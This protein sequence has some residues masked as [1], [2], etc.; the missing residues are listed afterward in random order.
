MG[1][2][3]TAVEPTLPAYGGPYVYEDEDGRPLFRIRRNPCGNPR[4]I[5]EH[6]GTRPAVDTP[7]GGW[8]AHEDWLPGLGG[9]RRVLYR[10]PQLIAASQRGVTEVHICSGEKDDEAAEDV[11]V[12]ATTN[13][14]GETSRWLD[15]YSECLRS[16]GYTKFVLHMDNDKAGWQHVRS[17]ADSLQRIILG[18]TITVDKAKVGNDLWDHLAAGYSLDEMVPVDLGDARQEPKAVG[19]YGPLTHGERVE[20]AE[21]VKEGAFPS[22][23]DVAGS[24]LALRRLSSIEEGSIDWLWQ[25]V[26]ARGAPTMWEGDPDTGKTFSWC[27]VVS[28]V[29]TGRRMPD[30]TKACLPSSVIII[31]PE[32]SLAK[33]IKPR[34]RAAGGDM[35]RVYAV[36]LKR[37]DE[38]HLIPLFIDEALNEIADLI[39]QV[40]AALIV[41][42]PITGLV[43]EKVSTHTSASVRRMLTPL[44][45]I[46]D[47]MN[48]AA[49]MIRHLNQSGELKAIYRGTGSNAFL[50]VARA[51]LAVAYHP[52][53][54]PHDPRRLRCLIQTKGNLTRK[55][56][57]LGFHVEDDPE[58]GI[59]R[60]VWHQ[61][62]LDLDADTLLQGRD[63]RKDAPKR[64]EAEEVLS[65]IL[66]KGPRRVSGEDGVEAETKRAGVTWGT[67]KRAADSLKVVKTRHYK[68]G[69][70]VDYVTWELPVTGQS[71]VIPFNLPV[72]FDEPRDS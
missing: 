16:L 54:D 12:V 11:G 46:L 10:L 28:R 17:V 22:V 71:N 55:R 70:G 27:D 23:Q 25:E 26:I 33:T 37:D 13:V 31:A 3:T 29:T 38:G 47:E 20:R 14:F 2:P 51:G 63:A 42:D 44:G 18:A 6:W 24:R 64:E 7:F 49:L 67:V 58:T 1:K 68:P 9:Q 8:D 48:V 34:I 72:A 4:F 69:G 65:K 50:E 36:E 66:S 41:F 15:E 52:D 32:D 39:R 35:D 43:S 45:G 19:T 53:S 60:V 40:N 59:G 30:S 5:T 62:A 21:W 61:G 56:L 57:A